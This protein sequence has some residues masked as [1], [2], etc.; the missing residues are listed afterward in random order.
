MNP[1]RRSYLLSDLTWTEVAAHLEQDRRLIV[2]VGA[3]DQYG[4]HLP[5]GTSTFIAEAM[6]TD[7]SQEFGVLRAP[8][9]AYGVNIETKSVYPGAAGMREKTLHR[10]LN[11][12]LASWEDQGFS[13]F[14]LITVH[15]YDPHVEGIAAV[16][17]LHARVRVIEALCIDFS[18]LLDGSGGPQHGGEVETSLLLYL[19]PEAV[20][21]EAAEDFLPHPRSF[22]LLGRGIP[23][24]P[25]DA[26]GSVG[27]PTLAS[28]EK[29]E[30]IYAH[31]LQ[32]IREK[33][34]LSAEEPTN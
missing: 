13:E 9:F 6:A 21:M 18:G 7:L 27:Q 14:L 24:L 34:F 33:I 26:P 32:K 23:T 11:D 28:A 19:R 25:P 31:I 4:R 30:R 22:T 8:T 2:P 3:C 29:G 10:A 17:V 20:N 12:L 1:P 15:G 16:S 5:I